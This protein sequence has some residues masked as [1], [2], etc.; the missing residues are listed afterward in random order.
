[1]RRWH[2]LF[3]MSKRDQSCEKASDDENEKPEEIEKEPVFAKASAGETKEKDEEIKQLKDQNLRMRAEFDNFRKRIEA[4]KQEFIKYAHEEIVQG[5]LPIMDSFDRALEEN[6]KED[7]SAKEIV[8]GMALINKQLL[9]AL[10]KFGVKKIEASGKKFDPYYHEAVMAEQSDAEAG[11]VIKEMQKGYI[12]EGK[13]I[14]HSMVI[15]SE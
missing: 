13:V 11:T 1:M 4:Q 9:D 2:C 10:S 6:T 14:R 8:E 3:M 5:I 7:H 12:L 15:I